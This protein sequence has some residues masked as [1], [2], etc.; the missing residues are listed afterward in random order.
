MLILLNIFFATRNWLQV[1]R[2]ALTQNIYHLSILLFISTFHLQPT[3]EMLLLVAVK[4]P[5]CLSRPH[6]Q[7][8]AWPYRLLSGCW[9]NV[10]RSWSNEQRKTHTRHCSLHTWEVRGG[11]WGSQCYADHLKV[12]PSACCNG[13]LQIDHQIRT[14]YTVMLS[15]FVKA[16]ANQHR[17]DHYKT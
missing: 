14:H 16:A 12:L 7:R 13:L 6:L 1:A 4:Q 8:A 2:S 17:D 5:F 10:S 9:V 15:C 3:E 11:L